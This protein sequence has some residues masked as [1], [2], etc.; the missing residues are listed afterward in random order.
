MWIQFFRPSATG[1]MEFSARLV[2]SSSSGYSKNRVSFFQSVTQTGKASH[3]AASCKSRPLLLHQ[4]VIGSDARRSFCEKSFD[5]GNT[6]RS[7]A[8]LSVAPSGVFLLC[9]IG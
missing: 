2:L 4:Q 6:G 3:Y 9:F 7:T 1:R 8:I 5:S